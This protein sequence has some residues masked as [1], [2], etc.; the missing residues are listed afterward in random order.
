MALE[1]LG[2][3]LVAPFVGL[4]PPWFAAGLVVVVVVVVVD[5]LDVAAAA[6]RGRRAQLWSLGAERFELERFTETEASAL[7]LGAGLGDFPVSSTWRASPLPFPLRRAVV[8]DDDPRA[9][10]EAVSAAPCP[11]VLETLPALGAG[12]A[13]SGWAGVGWTG[14]VP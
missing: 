7:T 2:A 11:L 12:P 13:L 3:E 1:R 4:E 10:F 14:L 5:P 9:P 8:V 6:V